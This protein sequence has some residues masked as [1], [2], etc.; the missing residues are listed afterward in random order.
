MI[1]LV[2][3]SPLTH[4]RSLILS[5]LANRGFYDRIRRRDCP[6]C[7]S[8]FR[9]N[10]ITGFREKRVSADRNGSET[11]GAQRFRHR[12]RRLD[13]RHRNRSMLV[14]PVASTDQLLQFRIR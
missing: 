10:L 12:T 7:I 4:R 8:N 9:T 14:L 11:S 13:V 1:F 6:I 5:K 2:I 3:R